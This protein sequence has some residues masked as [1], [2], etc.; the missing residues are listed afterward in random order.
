MGIVPYI[1]A[2]L[3]SIHLGAGVVRGCGR[4]VAAPYISVRPR[5]VQLGASIPSGGGRLVAAPAVHKK[6]TRAIVV[7]FFPQGIPGTGMKAGAAA[8]GI[9][10]WVRS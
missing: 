10:Q 1:P 6:F 8:G 5:I 2:G 3:H 9:V 4:L 7:C